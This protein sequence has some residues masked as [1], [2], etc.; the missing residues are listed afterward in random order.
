MLDFYNGGKHS[1]R[2]GDREFISEQIDL[3]PIAIQKKVRKRYGSIYLQLI[4][5]DKNNARFRANSWLRATVK[6]YKAVDDGSL[7]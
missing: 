3:L 5:E 7:F 4:K 2:Y 1:A 6:K